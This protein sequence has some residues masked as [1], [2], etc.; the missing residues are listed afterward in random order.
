METNKIKRTVSRVLYKYIG[1]NYDIKFGVNQII[2]DLSFWTVSKSDKG[3]VKRIKEELKENISNVKSI[4][5]G[6]HETS[7]DDDEDYYEHQARIGII[8]NNS[9]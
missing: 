7:L 8:I 9:N 6:K 4:K 2:I 3:I 1:D 5:V